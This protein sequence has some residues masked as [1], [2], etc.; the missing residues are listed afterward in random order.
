MALSRNWKDC[1]ASSCP[2]TTI[3]TTLMAMAHDVPLEDVQESHISVVMIIIL[4]AAIVV[5]G[6]GSVTGTAA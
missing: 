1:I 4:V 2:S 6:E 3:N 5:V